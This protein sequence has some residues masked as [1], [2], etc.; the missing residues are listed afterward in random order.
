[1]GDQS[2]AVAQDDPKL[3][4]KETPDDQLDPEQI[5]A[6]LK[7]PELSADERERLEAKR[8]EYKAA[9]THMSQWGNVILAEA[10]KAGA[11][12]QDV[13]AYLKGLAGEAL[14]HRK[15]AHEAKTNKD[16][17]KE[18]SEADSKIK[19]LADELDIDPEKLSKGLS[20]IFEKLAAKLKKELGEEIAPVK[21]GHVAQALKSGYR[22]FKANLKEQYPDYEIPEDLYEKLEEDAK[23]LITSGEMSAVEAFD[24]IFIRMAHR[25]PKFRKSLTSGKAEDNRDINTQRLKV[26][27][28]RARSS[29]EPRKIKLDE[30]I[31]QA[32]F[33]E[34]MKRQKARRK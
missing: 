27:G 24:E 10:K 19:E 3:K 26:D 30:S 4:P 23:E 16:K 29:G 25:D 5:E 15:K 21:K 1:M 9:Y 28:G 17:E 33:P 7:D 18:T 32:F 14:E 31:K 13:Y 11:S 12:P 6:K 8:K 34:A 2:S 20:P 22:E